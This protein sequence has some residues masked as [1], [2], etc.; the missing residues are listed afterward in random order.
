LILIQVATPWERRA[1]SGL[2]GIELLETGM[3]R[4]AVKRALAARL[5]SH[6][7]LILSAGFAGALRAGMNPGD[8]VVDLNDAGSEM[9][10]RI[11]AEARMLSIP[12]HYGTIASVD[13]VLATPEQKRRLA[14]DGGAIA[15]DMEW[16]TV[17][18]WAAQ[19]G[20]PSIAIKTIFDRLDDSLPASAPDNQG[21]A[22]SL[23]FLAHRPL[24]LHRLLLLF[25]RQRRA[26]RN[27]SAFLRKLLR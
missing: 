8:L 1:L 6:P 27:L 2:E 14:R 15:V 18:E 24:E 23:R 5:G 3:G 4:A 22:A 13:A 9:V 12:R 11:D 17:R 10:A 25:F 20:I 19:R 26:A 7:S 21:L 16:E